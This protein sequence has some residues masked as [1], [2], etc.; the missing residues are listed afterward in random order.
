MTDQQ[1]APE[2]EAASPRRVTLPPAP[3]PFQIN[4]LAL[5]SV[6]TLAVAASWLILGNSLRLPPLLLAWWPLAL[7]GP[8]ALWVFVALVRR[9][10][11]GLLIGSLLLGVA[12]ALL[13]NAQNILVIRATW[14]GVPALTVGAGLLLRGLLMQ[15]QPLD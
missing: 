1:S 4:L 10:P 9:R 14:I 12:I 8:A 6:V 5:A 2:A 11:N 15:A 7:V 13:L 3:P